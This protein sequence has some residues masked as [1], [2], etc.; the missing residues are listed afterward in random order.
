MNVILDKPMKKGETR[1][2]VLSREMSGKLLFDETED[3][4]NIA[5]RKT[6]RLRRFDHGT[7]VSRKDSRL[8]IVL[9]VDENVCSLADQLAMSDE[10]CD[11]LNYC[12]RYYERRTRK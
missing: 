2:G 1:Q 6:F 5:T 3:W 4:R 9:E 7:R 11:A 12:A 10:L 8:R